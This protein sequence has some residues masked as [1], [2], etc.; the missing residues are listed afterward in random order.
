MTMLNS[1]SML[2]DLTIHRWTATKHDPSVSAEVERTHSAKNAGRY[3]KLLIDRAH[4]ADIDALGNQLRAF[5]YKHTLPWSDKGARILPSK[6][7]MTYQDGFNDLRDK[8][9]AAVDKF[10]ELY[11]SLVADARTRLKTMFDPFD[12]P[13]VS[14]LRQSFG[15]D[16]EIMPVP[17][18]EDFRVGVLN[19]Q[20]QSAIRRDI[21]QKLEERGK[22]ANRECWLRVDEV[23]GRIAEQCSK[24][25]GR[26]YDSLMDN[27]RDLALVIDGLNITDD[28]NITAIGDDLRALIVDPEDLR[29]SVT[30]RA[31]IAR[32]AND[33]LQRVPRA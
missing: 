18:A 6:L 11:P 3:N 31:A 12:Y 19:D 24:P 22:Q 17:S 7:F 8:R 14:Q 1:C 32:L 26:I 10:I 15:V 29:K 33:I 25:K 5:H 28:P 16:L 27:A 2:A 30:T 13:D 20:M 9:S 4:L 21:L 23:V